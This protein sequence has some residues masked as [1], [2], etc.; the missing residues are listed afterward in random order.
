M[1]VLCSLR[2]MRSRPRPAS[3]PSVLGWN[4]VYCRKSIRKTLQV[5]PNGQGED[6]LLVPPFP[7]IEVTRL[8][9]GTKVSAS[10][11]L[12]KRAAP[13]GAASCGTAPGAAKLSEGGLELY[14]QEAGGLLPKQPVFFRQ[15]GVRSAGSASTIAD[16]AACSLDPDRR[17]FRTARLEHNSRRAAAQ[18]WP[19]K[20]ANLVPVASWTFSPKQA[21]WSNAGMLRSG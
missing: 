21:T 20:V 6:L 2:W 11:A 16:F 12:T 17:C 18:H 8:G 1:G 7:R 13:G 10:R 19:K 4:W 3:S 15:R 9:R 5:T 14:S